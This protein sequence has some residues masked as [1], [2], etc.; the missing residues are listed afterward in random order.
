M[1]SSNKQEYLG[2]IL[3]KLKIK[4]L[5]RAAQEWNRLGSM[6][7]GKKKKDIVSE[8]FKQKYIHL[9]KIFKE[10]YILCKNDL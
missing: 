10:N 3:T 8:E 4:I 1:E 9:P 6:E 5:T 2:S 7:K